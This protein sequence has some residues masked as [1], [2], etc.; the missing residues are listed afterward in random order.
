M[1][2]CQRCP[3][4]CEISGVI[5]TKQVLQATQGG[6]RKRMAMM[7]AHRESYTSC[8]IMWVRRLHKR[9]LVL[10]DAAQKQGLAIYDNS[11]I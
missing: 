5:A 8:R 3:C 4:P 2:V 6:A 7:Y 1:T 11:A 9:L 10:A